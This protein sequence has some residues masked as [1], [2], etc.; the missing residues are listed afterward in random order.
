MKT[1]RLVSATDNRTDINHT[2]TITT[3]VT[4]GRGCGRGR[5]RLVN[6]TTITSDRGR[7]QTKTSLIMVAKG[8]TTTYA[9]VRG[10]RGRTSKQI[11]DHHK[12]AVFVVAKKQ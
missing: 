2:T 8:T 9:L 6:T 10:R 5:G 11:F 12:W 4:A 3:T 7:C 1:N